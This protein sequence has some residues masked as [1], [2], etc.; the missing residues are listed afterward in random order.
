LTH[1]KVNVEEK[2]VE[3]EDRAECSEKEKA[4][5]EQEKASLEQE[6]A[7]LEQEKASL[8]REKAGLEDRVE[9]SEKTVR[10]I[11]NAKFF[12]FVLVY[13][14]LFCGLLFYLSD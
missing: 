14:S 6:K 4:D 7:S 1:D 2:N 12:L 5:L 13:L 9:R 3:L 8:E 10:T 11:N